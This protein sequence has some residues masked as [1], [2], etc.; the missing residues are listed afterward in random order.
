MVNRID[1]SFLRD[2][3]IAAIVA[4]IGAIGLKYYDLP[5]RVSVVESEI[6]G[7]QQTAQSVDHKLDIVLA[8]LH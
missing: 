7:I 4:I 8:R 5:T 2:T 1:G 3:V 6:S